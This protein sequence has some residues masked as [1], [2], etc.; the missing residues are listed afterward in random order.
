MK[1]EP[2]DIGRFLIVPGKRFHLALIKAKVRAGVMEKVASITRKYGVT[3]VYLSYSMQREY[4]KP[5]TAVAFLD[6]TD[7]TITA[8]ELAKEVRALDVVEEVREV[9]PEIEGFIC[10]MLSFPLVIGK[11]RVIIL[12]EQG[13][14]GI[15]CGLRKRLGSAA[16]AIQYF[17]GFE[18]G[19]EYGKSHI[20]LGKALGIKKASEIFS[21][22]SAPLFTPIG[23]GLMEVV[24]ITD[25]PPYALIRVYRCFECECCDEKTERPYSHLVRGMSAGLFTSLFKTEMFARET[26]CIAKGDPY[27]EFKITPQ[28]DRKS[29]IM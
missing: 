26:K 17:L 9:K 28:K 15:I 3:V 1:F 20:K 21:K 10:D 27:C 13:I 2:F 29:K 23:F 22:I 25:E 6:M 7:S 18:A 4:G 5:I 24:K 19:L 14:K 8:E 12:R 16:E 11:D